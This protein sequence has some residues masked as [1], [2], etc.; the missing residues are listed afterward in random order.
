MVRW[1]LCLNVDAWVCSFILVFEVGLGFGVG[2]YGVTC[3]F[4][5]LYL[6][7]CGR[8]FACSA[9]CLL[10]YGYVFVSWLRYCLWEFGLCCWLF[11]MPWG[12]LPCGLVGLLP[13]CNLLL[14]C[15]WVCCLLRRLYRFWR[16]LLAS[17]V[18]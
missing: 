13:L 10:I 2:S 8:A 5:V 3:L 15:V 18:G 14:D 12:W 17:S 7:E 4:L 11:W 6:I 16:S 9:V 1:S